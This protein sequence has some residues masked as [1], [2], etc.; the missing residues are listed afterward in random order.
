VLLE[1]AAWLEAGAWTTDP[2][3]AEIRDGR[4]DAFAG[5]VLDHRRKQVKH[6]RPSTSAISTLTRRHRLRLKGKT[7]RYAAE[8]L[9]PLFP[10]HPHRAER[11]VEATKT[12]QDTL[13]ALNDLSVRQGLVESV[14]HGD[15]TL[16]RD[17][18]RIVLASDE[19]DL[20][21]VARKAIAT[22]QNAKT[23]W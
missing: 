13:G 12:V 17:A 4:A 23:F 8:D 19:S 5:E 14:A 15:Q 7:L 20:L 6:P 2:A 22:L 3:L 18:A 11:F 9:S 1:A 10:D 21:D 16:A